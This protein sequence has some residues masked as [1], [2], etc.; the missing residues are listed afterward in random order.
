ME[1]RGSQI[2]LS[3]LSRRGSE[4]E[5]AVS[6]LEGSPV[7]SIHDLPP[8]I[9][10]VHVPHDELP[11]Y[12]RAPPGNHTLGRGHSTTLH[13]SVLVPFLTCLFVGLVVYSWVI[14]AI[15]CFRPISTKSWDV[16]T[17]KYGYYPKNLH[18]DFDVRL[19]R[20]ARIIQSIAGVLI[21]PWTSA[22][23]AYAAVVF[24]QNQKDSLGLSMR[25]MINLA[26]R[27]W[28]DLSLIPDLIAGN[29]KKHGSGFLALAILLHFLALIIYPIQSI[30]INPDMRH[31]PV[32]RN[33]LSEIGDLAH[34]DPYYD[35]NTGSDVVQTRDAFLGADQH[36]WQLHLWQNGGQQELSTFSNFSTMDDPF[37]APFPNGFNTG[38]IRQYS[39]RLNST[40]TV[41][42]IEPDEYPSDCNA[43]STNLFAN[44][45][46]SLIDDYYTAS[47]MVSGCMLESNIT[48]PWTATRNRQDFYEVLYLNVSDSDERYVSTSLSNGTLFEI[49]LR[50]TAGYF[51]LPNYMNNQ[52]AGLLLDNDP[53]T[54]CIDNTGN[55]IQ[56]T[57]E[58]YFYRRLRR[59]STSN[60]T[61]HISQTLPWDPLVTENKG[62]LLTTALAIFGPGSFL[63]TFFSDFS[64][65]GTNM[66]A[67]DSSENPLYRRIGDTYCI[68]VAPL[69]NMGSST[70]SSYISA[71]TC[72][73]A[74][75]DYDTYPA[76]YMA[77]QAAS[78]W[79]KRLFGDKLILANTVT[80]AAFLSNKHFVEALN[81]SYET[82]QDLGSKILVPH[83][84]LA[85]VIVVTIFLGPYILMLLALTVYGFRYP[86]WTSR[87]DSFAMLRIGAVYGEGF[88]PMLVSL[89]TRNAK[90]LDQ[91]PGVIRDV[92]NIADDAIIPIGRIGLGE[93]KPLRHGR[94]YE[95]YEGDNEPLTLTEFNKIRRGG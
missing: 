28:L 65:V 44:Y 88:F 56:Q 36:T 66:K 14:L 23:C 38:M 55:C 86:R 91:V 52:I 2:A 74:S 92:G 39:P 84:T 94:R 10:S 11:A 89:E 15:L 48:S 64:V 80:A 82:Y 25:Q 29:W 1:E 62:P 54:D 34:L 87:L 42:V 71:D 59:R 95:C 50:T 4:S 17:D 3:S 81:P 43:N 22:V 58:Y 69:M 18:Y 33:Q 90:E 13:R 45:S 8:H 57:D 67:A 83:S 27:R 31:I 73:M 76:S 75:A 37:Y 46:S 19:Y 32:A 40:A 41:R 78:S 5:R 63:D 49:S 6:P 20:S 9:D 26:D 79:I 93:G 30:V 60:I 53:T 61:E 12:S 16:R 35:D 85:G 47:W 7:H 77:H 51:E 68:E 24:V 72:V 70:I 21:L